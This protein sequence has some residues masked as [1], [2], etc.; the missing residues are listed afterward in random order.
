MI[1]WGWRKL[2]DQKKSM[3]TGRL[4]GIWRALD[5]TIRGGESGAASCS[6]QLWNSS[7]SEILASP[8]QHLIASRPYKAHR[9]NRPN[10]AQSIDVNTLDL[11]LAQTTTP[12]AALLPVLKNLAFLNPR[13]T[14]YMLEKLSRMAALQAHRQRGSSSDGSRQ[15]PG[16]TTSYQGLMASEQG[17]VYRQLMGALGGVMAG[18]VADCSPEQLRRGL[19]GLTKTRSLT[20]EQQR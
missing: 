9:V 15:H 8:P 10:L 20:S 18:L 2:G 6:F 4:R 17:E 16:V 3:N 13:Q 14:T 11:L 19:W 5:F 1:I 7:P 12:T